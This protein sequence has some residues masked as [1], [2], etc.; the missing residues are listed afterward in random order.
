LAESA[1]DVASLRAAAE[2]Q[3]VPV[4]E[5]ADVTVTTLPSALAAPAF[6]LEIGAAPIVV[7]SALG[8]HVL[9]ITD[10]T[11]ATVTPLADVSDTIRGDLALND[12]YEAVSDLSDALEDELAGGGSLADAA[13]MVAMEVRQIAVTRMG[14]GGDSQ[15]PLPMLPATIADAAFS[16]PLNEVVGP[17]DLNDGGIGYVV[18]VAD[19][20]PVTPPLDDI[21]GQLTADWQA[22]QRREATRARTEG[23]L[24]ALKVGEHADLAIQPLGPINRSMQAPGTPA[25]VHARLFEMAV[26]ETAVVETQDGFAAVLLDRIDGPEADT[27]DTLQ[28][29]IRDRLALQMAAEQT[30]MLALALRDEL[31]VNI[32]RSAIDR[33][34]DEATGVAF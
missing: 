19:V 16:A 4:S 27:R 23:V 15:A 3:G 7:Q 25:V 2:A 30:E 33:Y 10:I 14:L 17:I 22:D 18:A 12:A 5:I 28:T 32:N 24:T 26:G 6:A 21:R 8:W 9:L 29:T 20:D 34:Y 11:P 31:G 1:T 13:A